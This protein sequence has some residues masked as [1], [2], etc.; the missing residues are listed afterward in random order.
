MLTYCSVVLD[1]DASAYAAA[2]GAQDGGNAT[3]EEILQKQFPH[4]D[5]T[6]SQPAT[7]VDCAGVIQLWYG[8]EAFQVQ[9]Q[10]RTSSYSQKLD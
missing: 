10:V 8:P 3:F 2:V 6:L 1:W 9:R 5:L 4:P 7:I